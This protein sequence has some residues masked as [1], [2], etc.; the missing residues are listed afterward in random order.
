MT[1]PAWLEVL[2]ETLD[3]CRTHGRAD[4]A[5]RLR[6]RRD[7]PAGQSRLGVLGFPKQGKGYLLNA[8]LNA[9]VCAVGDAA[10][11]EVPTEIGYAPEPAANHD[12]LVRHC[13]L[14]LRAVFHG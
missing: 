2:N 9:P 10:T 1:A 5:E 8:V 7:A 13:R 3:A 6:R 14:F 4:L 12:Y 11:P